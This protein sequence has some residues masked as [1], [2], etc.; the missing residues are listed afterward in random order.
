MAS[1]RLAPVPEARSQGRRSRRGGA[2]EG[3]I[4]TTKAR[5]SALRLPLFFSR[6]RFPEPPTHA[7]R[8]AGS[9]DAWPKGGMMSIH[10]LSVVP[11]KAGTHSPWPSCCGD[12]FQQRHYRIAHHRRHGVWVP[13]FAGTTNVSVVT[14]P[15]IMPSQAVNPLK[16]P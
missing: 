13:A 12:A 9:D 1:L 16:N 7:D 5:L 11:A 14:T 8:F 6:A 15:K 2:S 3:R 4:F 10:T